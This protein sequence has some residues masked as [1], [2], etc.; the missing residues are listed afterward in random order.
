MTNNP[1][2]TVSDTHVKNINPYS[3]I[4]QHRPGSSHKSNPDTYLKTQQSVAPKT[5]P[6][7]ILHLTPYHAYRDR[8]DRSWHGFAFHRA[9]CLGG[10]S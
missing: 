4:Q 1:Q 10:I 6:P 3:I 2:T 5:T 7:F 9:D 8:L